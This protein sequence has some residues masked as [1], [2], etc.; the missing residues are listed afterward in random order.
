MISTGRTNFRAM[1]EDKTAALYSL[2]DIV[3]SQIQEMEDN[4][5]HSSNVE[6]DFLFDIRETFF[7][8]IVKELYSLSEK[9]LGELSTLKK[10]TWPKERGKRPAD[11]EIYYL[12]IQE[13]S[14]NV[15]PP[16]N[17]VW[18][19]FE[20]FHIIRTINTHHKVVRI[21]VEC[22]TPD[23]NIQLTTDYLKRNIEQVKQMLLQAEQAVL[24]SKKK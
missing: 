9:G 18:R 20:D 1:V 16:I 3:S 13:I 6:P 14:G 15:L 5:K 4:I 21:N 17:E 19:D 10:A 11:I 24:D 12:K 8:S 23:K 2:L 22:K 7:Q